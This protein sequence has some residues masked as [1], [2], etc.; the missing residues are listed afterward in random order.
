M[1]PLVTHLLC[2]EGEEREVDEPLGP[3]PSLKGPGVDDGTK[4]VVSGAMVG[5]QRT[6]TP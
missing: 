3:A 4:A 1:D 6:Q 5:T 2:P